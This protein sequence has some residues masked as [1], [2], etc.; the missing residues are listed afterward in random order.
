MN[1]G[2]R[3]GC[4]GNPCGSSHADARPETRPQRA[5]GLLDDRQ[6]P[7][8]HQALGWAQPTVERRSA[9]VRKIRGDEATPAN[10]PRREAQVC[11]PSGPVSF[12]RARRGA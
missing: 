7:L 6:V 9:T 5:R 8:L 3:Y 11:A 1:R 10:G 4:T 12:M 2:E